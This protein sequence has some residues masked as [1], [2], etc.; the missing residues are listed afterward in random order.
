MRKIYRRLRKIITRLRG[1]RH[2][3]IVTYGRSGSTLLMNVLNSADGCCVRGENNGALYTLFESYKGVL[4]AQQY[5]DFVME[6]HRQTSPW[7]GLSDINVDEY[8]K[9]LAK[10]FVAE[11]IHPPALDFLVGFK[12]IRYTDDDIDDL[13]G[14]L[15]FVV[16]SFPNAKIVFNHRNLP[17][18]IKSKWWATWPNVEAMMASTEAKFNAYESNDTYFHFSYDKAIADLAHVGELFDFL[19]IRFNRARVEQVLAVR[20]SY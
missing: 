12:E 13:D 8:G 5:R 14:F 20:H 11:I 1:R 6:S 10:A 3:F 17:D 7:F 15:K 18:V 4:N 9:K 19:D 2:V 16:K